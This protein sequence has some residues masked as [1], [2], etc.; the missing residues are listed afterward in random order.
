LPGCRQA[1]KL[2][3]Y[4]VSSF[5]VENRMLMAKNKAGRVDFGQ[6]DFVPY[7]GLAATPVK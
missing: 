4:T 1:A 6:S 7:K 5:I 3:D 2:R